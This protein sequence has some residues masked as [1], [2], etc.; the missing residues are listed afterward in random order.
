MF[1]IHPVT[2]VSVHVVRALGKRNVTVDWATRAGTAKAGT[3]FM[4][5]SGTLSWDATDVSSRTIVVPITSGVEVKKH[6]HTYTRGC[7]RGPL[8]NT[9]IPLTP[10]PYAV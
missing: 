1:G 8:A 9:V 5:S 10:P 2:K 4:T 3:D 6:A 7:Y